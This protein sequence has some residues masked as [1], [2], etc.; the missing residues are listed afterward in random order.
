MLFT[1]V[2]STVS[3]MLTSMF[4]VILCQQSFTVVA[5]IGQ[6]VDCMNVAFSRG[7]VGEE[8]YHKCQHEDSHSTGTQESASMGMTRTAAV[9]VKLHERDG[10]MNTIIIRVVL[11]ES[12]YPCKISLVEMGLE[13][14]H[15]MCKN[16]RWVILVE[17][18][19]KRDHMLLLSRRKE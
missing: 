10:R 19:E 5:S 13:H 18:F 4:I 3:T 6:T 1:D 2:Q 8:N 9:E 12:S 17:C 14:A 15:A 16:A 11:S 7:G